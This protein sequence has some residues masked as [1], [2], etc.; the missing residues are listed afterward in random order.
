MRTL[1]RVEVAMFQGPE[2]QLGSATS[3]RSPRDS[4]Y[5]SNVNAMAMLYIYIIHTI[6]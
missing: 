6:R 4:S 5:K 1:T 3:R 2:A